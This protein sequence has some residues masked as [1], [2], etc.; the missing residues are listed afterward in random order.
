VVVRSDEVRK[1]LCGVEPL[2][3]LGPEGYTPEVSRQVYRTITG[4][5]RTVV[6]DGHAAIV[7]AVFARP[8]DRDA[9][10][11]A[12]AA[13]G[14]PF[15]GLWL[16]A[17]ESAL[18]ARSERRRLDPSD[19]DAAVVRAQLAQ[20]IGLIRWQRI[21]TSSA[22]EKVLQNATAVVNDR[23]KQPMVRPEPTPA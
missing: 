3:R 6:A 22:S 4:R 2:V 20:D 9:I 8:A 18:V 16:D 1:R 7:D 12:A 23:L 10:E 14:V 5:A 19:A 17:P 11:R 15:V 13:A 21:E